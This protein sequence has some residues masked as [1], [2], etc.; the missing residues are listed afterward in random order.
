MCLNRAIKSRAVKSRNRQKQ[1]GFTLIEVMLVIVI[2]S[3]FAA[4]VVVSISGVEQRKLMQQRDQLINDLNVVRLESSDQARV[5]ALMTTSAT[6]TAPAGYF[7]AEYQVPQQ[8]DPATLSTQTQ[9]SARNNTTNQKPLW[10]AVDGFKAR[11]LEEGALLQV[12]S[13]DNS[14]QVNGPEGLLGRQSPDLIWFGNGEVKPA[15]LQFIFNNQP[16]GSPIYINSTGMV[17]DTEQGG[18]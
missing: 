10:Q 15:R 3:I 7:F 16:I 4:L 11:T 13:M 6:A 12:R 1:R 2:M 17:S 8:A 14:P 18:Q 5:Y 9:N